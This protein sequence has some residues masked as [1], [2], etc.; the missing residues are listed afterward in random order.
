MAYQLLKYQRHKTDHLSD[1]PGHQT[2]LLPLTS[3]QLAKTMHI[4]VVISNR[5]RKPIFIFLMQT[6]IKASQEGYEIPYVLVL[7]QMYLTVYL[8]FNA[9]NTYQCMRGLY[10]TSLQLQGYANFYFIISFRDASK[11]HATHKENHAIKRFLSKY[12]ASSIKN[13]SKL[14][15]FFCLGIFKKRKTSKEIKVVPSNL[16]PAIGK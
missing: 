3:E 1:I 7:N 9:Y 13:N 11:L 12:I 8:I 16:I 14:T 6:K 4:L 5:W 2:A 15:L 10:Q